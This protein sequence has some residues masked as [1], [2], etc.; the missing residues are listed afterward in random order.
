[1][2]TKLTLLLLLI[3]TSCS[4]TQKIKSK[5]VEETKTESLVTAK[6]NSNTTTNTESNTVTIDTTNTDETVIE[7]IDNSKEFTI[8]GKTYKN[9]RIKTKKVKSGVSVVNS[10]K[11]AKNEQKD[12]KTTVEAKVENRKVVTSKIVK[13]DPTKQIIVISVLIVGAIVFLAWWFLGIGKRKNKSD[14]KE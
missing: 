5:S 3:L 2:K 8:N 4:S 1:M 9:A 11:V 7:P 12:V 10:E 13:R 14:E 6:D